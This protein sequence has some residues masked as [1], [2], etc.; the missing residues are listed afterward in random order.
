M[1]CLRLLSA[2]IFVV[3]VAVV[4][5]QGISRPNASVL[6]E[7]SVLSGH[8]VRDTARVSTCILCHPIHMR[9]RKGQDHD[10]P[11]RGRNHDQPGMGRTHDQPGMVRTHD[12]P[13]TLPDH[14]HP[15]TG[16]IDDFAPADSVESW[17]TATLR[18]WHTEIRT[19]VRDRRHAHGGL[20]FDRGVF[21]RLTPAMDHEYDIDLLTYGYTPADDAVWYARDHGIRTFMGSIHRSRFATRTRFRHEIALADRHSALLDAMQQEDLTAQRFF[22]EVGYAYQLAARHR[23]GFRQTVAS[24]KPDLDLTLTYTYQSPPIG[25][26]QAE[27]ALLDVA[28]NLIFERLGVDPVLEDTVRTYRQ[29]PRLLDLTWRSPRI[30]PLRFEATIGIQPAAHARV[31]S[32]QNPGVDFQWGERLRY[33][34]ALVEYRHPLATSGVI[35]HHTFSRMSREAEAA[36]GGG[37]AYSAEQT[38]HAATIYALAPIWRVRAGLW[39]TAE[40]Y[41]DHQSGSGFH[42]ATIPSAMRYRER[43]V[44]FQARVDYVPRRGVRAGLAYLVDHRR[45]TDGASLM[46]EYLRFLPWSP[47]GRVAAN[48][49]YQF[50]EVGYAVVGVAYDVGGDPFYSDD[51]G[52]VRYDGGF[53]RVV[54]TWR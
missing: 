19:A 10:Q 39:L 44:T 48:V 6:L 1:L 14:D 3:C 46:N 28:N 25:T 38:S 5:R 36:A 42:D 22:I 9:S 13:G 31:R 11:G 17:R 26:I 21:R 7:A 16:R 15:G 54:V 50:G 23:I 47:N 2:V 30:G 51:R 32:H 29:R 52:P 33:V 37:T 35:Y 27:L 53:G 40:W 34:G 45:F 41:S 20:F 18:G 4:P 24:Y 49:G 43:R 12:H 8:V